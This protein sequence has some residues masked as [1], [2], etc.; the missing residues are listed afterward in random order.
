[1]AF[2]AHVFVSS[3]CYELRDLRAALRVWLTERGLIPQMSDE[4]GFPHIAGVHPYVSCLPVLEQC[5]LV[6]GV[7]DRAYGAKFSDWHPIRNLVDARQPMPN[8][9]MHSI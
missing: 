5:P 7:I 6:V 9:D 8:C 4:G 1:M 3:S 2:G